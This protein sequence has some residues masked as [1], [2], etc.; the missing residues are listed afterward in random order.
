VSNKVSFKNPKDMTIDEIN[1]RL[2]AELKSME[3]YSGADSV[4][5]ELAARVM[6]LQNELTQRS[7]GI[8]SKWAMCIA[9]LSIL[10]TLFFSIA[11]FYSNKSWQDHQLKILERIVNNTIR[12]EK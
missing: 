1:D 9:I 11:N 8:W 12:I 4:F 10:V 7:A 6:Q 5:P 3:Q 2:V